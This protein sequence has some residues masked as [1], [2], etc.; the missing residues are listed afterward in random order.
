MAGANRLPY[1]QTPRKYFT[2]LPENIFF[3]GSLHFYDINLNSKSFFA[4]LTG[5]FRK[6]LDYNR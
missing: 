3:F 1:P 2:S 6:L 5:L 4:R